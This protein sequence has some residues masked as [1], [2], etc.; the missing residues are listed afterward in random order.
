MIKNK[1]LLVFILQTADYNETAYYHYASTTK[2][3]TFTKDSINQTIE[4]PIYDDNYKKMGGVVNNVDF[5]YRK[6]A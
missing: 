1:T 4:V 6:V 2:S 5:R 3:I